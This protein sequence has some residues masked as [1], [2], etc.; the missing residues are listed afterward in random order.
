[1]EYYKNLSLEPI[2]YFCDYDLKWKV[3]EWKDIKGYEGIYQISDLGRV[4]SLRR[5]ILNHGI[6]SFYSKNK[7]LKS[8]IL[9]NGYSSVA[10]RV[11]NK[12]KSF[13]VHILVSVSFLNH[14]PCG[15]KWVINHKNFIKTDNRKL[16]LEI[17]SNRE[18]SNQK[19]IKSSSEYVGVSWNK[20]SCKWQSIIRINGKSVFL[21]LHLDELEAHNAYQ[22]KLKEITEK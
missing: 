9:K 3:E 2:I 4:K 7:I 11:N 12:Q 16:N 20:G 17:V 13:L 1:M 19:H 15:F 21:G 5:I 10:L 18:N 8:A 22:E 14:V 6:N